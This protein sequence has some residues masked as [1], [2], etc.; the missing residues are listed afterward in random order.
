MSR[1]NIVQ[2]KFSL[3][4]NITQPSYL[5]EYVFAHAVLKDCHTLYVINH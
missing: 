3:D 5:V 1:N 4:K 2:P